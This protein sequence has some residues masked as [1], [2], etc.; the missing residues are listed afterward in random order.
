[1][2]RVIGDLHAKIN[3]VY[4]DKHYFAPQAVGRTYMSII[5]GCEATLQIGDV[6]WREPLKPFY[7]KTINPDK[8]KVVL[9]NHDDYDNRIPHQLGDFG[10]YEHGGVRFGFIR[11]ANSPDYMQRYDDIPKTWWKEEELDYQTAQL[12][13][14]FFENQEIDLFISHTCPGFLVDP[15]FGLTPPHAKHWRPTLTGELLSEIYYSTIYIKK[16][17]FGHYHN[18]WRLTTGGT[19]FI[20]LNELCYLD[21]DEAGKIG[22]II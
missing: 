21:I 4:S 12:A 1:M 6:G 15:K 14:D 7:D 20:C 10:I 16:W 22:E 9:G 2:L 18:N 19:E 8:H 17:I 11:G 3:R 13:L 5:E